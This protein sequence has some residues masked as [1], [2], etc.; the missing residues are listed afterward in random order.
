M[1]QSSVPWTPRSTR[2]EAKVMVKY[3]LSNDISQ[4]LSIGIHVQMSLVDVVP[5]VQVQYSSV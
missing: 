2:S 4:E 3:S 5:P 1:P